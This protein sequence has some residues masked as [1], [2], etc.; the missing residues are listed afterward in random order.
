MKK[1]IILFMTVVIAIMFSVSSSAAN[2]EFSG[3]M[4]YSENTS[5]DES[6]YGRERIRVAHIVKIPRTEKWDGLY[7]LE[8][9]FKD[10][11]NE[12]AFIPQVGFRYYPTEVVALHLGATVG[13]HM[14]THEGFEIKPTI[15]AN[16][17]LGRREVMLEAFSGFD[18]DKDF[19]VGVRAGYIF[20][21]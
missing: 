16:I 12:S 7:G 17:G 14:E 6:E 19:C 21:F 18:D 15:E 20:N 13:G 3:A 10:G 1:Y 5:G 11:D 8:Y 2:I 9:Q 4:N